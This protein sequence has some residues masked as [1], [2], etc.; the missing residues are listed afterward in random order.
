MEEPRSN[1]ISS[2]RE[3]DRNKQ[4][5]VQVDQQIISGLGHSHHSSDSDWWNQTL[6]MFRL[7]KAWKKKAPLL[8]TDPQLYLLNPS[9]KRSKVQHRCD[10][11]LTANGVS[12]RRL[13]V[14]AVDSLKDEG[15]CTWRRAYIKDLNTNTVRIGMLGP[16]LQAW[17]QNRHRDKEWAAPVS[18]LCYAGMWIVSLVALILWFVSIV[19]RLIFYSKV[20]LSFTSLVVALFALLFQRPQHVARDRVFVFRM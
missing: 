19:H 7:P 1:E 14:Q 16:H 8:Y 20:S 12:S 13:K 17:F 6:E 5:E 4:P 10:L 15:N 3:S 2:G 18:W 9:H 11:P